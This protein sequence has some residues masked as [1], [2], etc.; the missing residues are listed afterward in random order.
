[1]QAQQSL[2]LHKRSFSTAVAI[3]ATGL[4]TALALALVLTIER[5]ATSATPTVVTLRG[6]GAEQIAHN[7]LEE[8]FGALGSVDGE[9]VAH[10]RSEVGLANH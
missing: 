10:D 4:A 3:F 6:G 5:P 9:Q 7:R 8:G 2:T 1:M